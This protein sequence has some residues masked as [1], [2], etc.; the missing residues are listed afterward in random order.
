M[1]IGKAARF[2]LI[3]TGVLAAVSVAAAPAD[4]ITARQKNY[5]QIGKAFKAISDNLKTAP[6]VKLI[7]ANAPVIANLAPKVSTWFPAGTGKE[8]GVKT[9]ALPAIWS[10]RAEFDADAKKFAEAAAAFDGVVKKGNIDEIKVSAGALGKTCKGCHDT[11]RER[12]S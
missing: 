4:V 11:F 10:Q 5:K 12:E 1:L 8:A 9:A 6:D 2:A 7:Q 3:A